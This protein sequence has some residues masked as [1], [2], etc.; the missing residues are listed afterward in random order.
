MFKRLLGV[1]VLIFV[2]LLLTGVVLPWMVS[3]AS[4]VL[5]LG[6]VFLLIVFLVFSAN[7]IYKFVKERLK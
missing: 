1:A 2:L 4:N 6:G 7:Y 3:A 5:V